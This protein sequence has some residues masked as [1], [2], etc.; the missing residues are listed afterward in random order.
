MRDLIINLAILAIMAV[1]CA[2]AVQINIYDRWKSR[3]P[4]GMKRLDYMK[5]GITRRDSFQ[6]HCHMSS[7]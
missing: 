7:I 4:R 1:F 5:S 3:K 6:S 2:G